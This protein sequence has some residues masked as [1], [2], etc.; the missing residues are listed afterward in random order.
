[1]SQKRRL[2]PSDLTDQ[3]WDL[4]REKIPAARPGGRIRTTNIRRVVEAILY[5]T[6][7]GLA[8]RYLPSEFPPWQTVYFYFSK[9]SEMGLW[10]EINLV[11]TKEVRT[12]LSKEPIPSLA[13]VDS[14][15]TKAQYGERR[16][17]DG[18]KKV[19]GRKRSIIVDALGLIWSCEVHEANITDPKGG[20][21]ALEKFPEK[22]RDRLTKIIGDSAYRW[23]FDFYAEKT[24][25]L[26]VQLIERKKTGTNM[27]PKRWIVERTFAWF[28]RFRR[29]SRDYERLTR[30][31]EAMI[32]L[33]MITILL[34]RLTA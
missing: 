1:M 6:R 31:S 13:I 25:G 21:A 28:N 26:E 9:W 20:L 29:L 11:F 18:A 32:Y 14:Q 22:D 23:P 3:Q 19:R 30:N 2:Y 4:I 15:S 17:Y 34:R 33:A 8:W 16:G 7:T 27:K 10:T 12:K 5:V 24:F